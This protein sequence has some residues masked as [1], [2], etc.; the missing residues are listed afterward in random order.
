[1][2][3]QR[4]QGAAAIPRDGRAVS[5]RPITGYALVVDGQL[6]SEFKAKDRAFKVATDLKERFPMLQVEVYDA[7]AGRSEQIHPAAA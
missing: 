7:E 4:T 6:K 3:Q 2:R 5:E 1:M